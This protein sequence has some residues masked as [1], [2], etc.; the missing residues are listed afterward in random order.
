MEKEREGGE[1]EGVSK[2]EMRIKKGEKEILKENVRVGLT[3]RKEE[4]RLGGDGK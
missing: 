2:K 1:K 3:R 4:R